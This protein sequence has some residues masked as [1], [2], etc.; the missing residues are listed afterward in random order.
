[1]DVP[2][3]VFSVVEVAGD[4]EGAADT[5]GEFGCSVGSGGALDLGNGADYVVDGKEVLVLGLFGAVCCSGSALFGEVSEDL[6]GKHGL[7]LAHF[8]F[9]SLR[10]CQ[11]QF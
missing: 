11:R 10:S 7:G 8:F 6:N 2:G 9:S 4:D 1:M 3:E 5:A